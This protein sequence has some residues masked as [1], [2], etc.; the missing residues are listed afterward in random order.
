MEI[1]VFGRPSCSLDATLTAVSRLSKTLQW[2][3]QQFANLAAGRQQFIPVSRTMPCSDCT[4]SPQS[5][6]LC[7]E[8]HYCGNG[9]GLSVKLSTC[10]DPDVHSE[11]HSASSHRICLQAVMLSDTPWPSCAFL[12]RLWWTLHNIKMDF[13]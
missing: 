5:S 6:P 11:W 12:E 4:A 13:S 1:R 10:C 8:G 3:S 2:L 9:A 7:K